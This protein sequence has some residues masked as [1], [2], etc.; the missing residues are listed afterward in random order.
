M[1]HFEFE[2]NVEKFSKT[3]FLLPGSSREMGSVLEESFLP[4]LKNYSKNIKRNVVLHVFA[5]AES[6]VEEITKSVMK[7]IKFSGLESVKFDILTDELVVDIKLSVSAS[8]EVFVNKAIND[9]KLKFADVLKDNIFGFDGDT[10]EFVTGRLLLENKK[11]ISFAESCS[12]GMIA[13][14]V[15]NVSGSSSYFKGSVIVYIQTI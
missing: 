4:F 5:I 11:T 13:A 8:S 9:L 1:L 2:D 6:A 15:T 3:L 12:G 10:I 14:A 7:E